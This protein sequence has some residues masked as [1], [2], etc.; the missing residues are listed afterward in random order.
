M[1]TDLSSQGKIVTFA[2]QG[3]YKPQLT[4]SLFVIAAIASRKAQIITKKD[5][6]HKNKR[7]KI[8][9]KTWSE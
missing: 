7:G 3:G 8:L 6:Q 9:E 4:L 5:E 1:E 2:F